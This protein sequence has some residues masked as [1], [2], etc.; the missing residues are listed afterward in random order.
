MI[1]PGR[2]L[3]ASILAVGDRPANQRFLSELLS[4]RGYRVRSVSGGAQAIAAAQ[5]APPDLIL[6]DIHLPEMDG[7]DVG[8]RLKEDPLTSTIPILFLGVR[9]DTEERAMAYAAGGAD[10]ITEPFQASELLARVQT[11]LALQKLGRELKSEIAE[12]DGL[13]ADLQSYA[14][15]VAHDLRSPMTG[16]LGFAQLLGETDISLSDGDRRE[17]IHLLVESLEQANNIIEELLLLAEVR[18]SEL[19]LEPLDM[20]IIVAQSVHRIAGLVRESG[21]LL[22]YPESWPPAIGY[23]AWVEEVW[24]NYITNAIKYGGRPPVIQLGGS[25]GDNGEVRFWVQD[26]G[27]GI[28]VDQQAMLFVPF[29]RLD[30][31]RATGHGLGLSI[32]QRIVQKLNGCVGIESNGINGEGSRFYFTLPSLLSGVHGS[33]L[34][35][36][37]PGE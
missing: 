37:A 27:S 5:V 14:H 11:Q 35:T 2:A 28:S 1:A 26:N 33:V 23:P 34:S 36:P 3:T 4:E 30:M 19:A 31:T 8:R 7:F 12:R 9:H 13:I 22:L 24:V 17:Y 20:T 10:Y 21:A 25:P 18:G 32:V 16:A 6:L 29:T 15:S